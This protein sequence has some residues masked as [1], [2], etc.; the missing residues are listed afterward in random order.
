MSRLGDTCFHILEEVG[1]RHIED[2]G[3]VEQAAGADAIGAA[4]VF[5]HLLEGEADGF[6]Q[7][8]LA[9]AQQRAPL[10]DALTDMDIDRVG[11]TFAGH[12]A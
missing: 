10:A 2:P 12:A 1:D 6:R 7:P 9:H 11:E 3:Q 8:L 4:L 5:L